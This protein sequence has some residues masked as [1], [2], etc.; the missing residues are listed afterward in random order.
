MTT[1]II[2]F[3]PVDNT[4]LT[5]KTDRVILYEKFA[6]QSN[7]PAH[8]FDM[9]ME[10]TELNDDI[11]INSNIPSVI[12]KNVLKFC[13]PIIKDIPDIIIKAK[14]VDI[15]NK[16]NKTKPVDLT[17]HQDYY[18]ISLQ[19]ESPI[20][21][22]IENDKYN[23]LNHI[24]IPKH[25]TFNI[26]GLLIPPYFAQLI[27]TSD[28]NYFNGVH[29]NELLMTGSYGLNDFQSN[30]FTQI[31]FDGLRINNILNGND[32]IY[33]SS[34]S[35]SIYKIGIIT[36]YIEHII[37]QYNTSMNML[38]RYI[39][40]YPYVDYI[41]KISD[42]FNI[43]NYT[44]KTFNNKYKPTDID[45]KL[46]SILQTAVG[47][48]KYQTDFIFN[49]NNVFNEYQK[50]TLLGINNSSSKRI[51]QDLNTKNK[52]TEIMME[53][54]KMKFKRLLEY[55]K[56]RAIS[57]RKFNIEQLSNLSEA[58]NKILIIEY[59]KNEKKKVDYAEYNDVFKLVESLN[60]FVILGNVKPIQN[61]MNEL[62]K[63]IT[64]P[65]DLNH[66]SKDMAMI[67]NSK[68]ISIVCPHLIYKAQFIIKHNDN[69]H[70]QNSKDHVENIIKIR[71]NIINKYALPIVDSGYFC[72]I[73]GELL[74]E[75][76]EE[77]I[78]KYISGKSTMSNMDMDPYMSVIW[79]EV[80]HIL[81]TYVKFKNTV[82]Y[83]ILV[84]SITSVLRPEM[85]M[86]LVNLSKV[87]INSSDNIKDIMDIYITCYTM[88]LVVNMILK[89]YGQISLV[90]QYTGGSS[91]KSKHS[92]LI[93]YK[94]KT[95]SKFIEKN[96]VS[97]IPIQRNQDGYEADIDRSYDNTQ[98]IIGGDDKTDQT[99]ITDLL[100]N[101][102]LLIL[103]IKNVNINKL[104]NMS[105]DSIKPILLKAYKWVT[106]LKTDKLN[107][108]IVDRGGGQIDIYND[109]ICNYIKYVLKM[110]NM[111]Q[112]SQKSINNKLDLK[113]I[114]GRTM[115]EIV[116][117][118]KKDKSIYETAN[119]G[120]QWVDTDI[121]KYK[122]NSYICM[123]EY[124]KNKLYLRDRFDNNSEFG[125]HM[126]K[127][128]Y[129]KTIEELIHI[130]YKIN[131]L[132]PFNAI[133]MTIIN[134]MNDFDPDKFRIDKLYDN[135]GKKHKFDIYIYQKSNNRGVLSG[136]KK[137][138]T[139]SDIIKWM[140]D[141][142]TKKI[143][144][145]K[146]WFIIDEKC[147]ICGDLLSQTKNISVDKEI[148]K[149][150]N[151]VNFYEYYNNK[152][153]KFDIHNYDNVVNSSNKRNTINEKQ[154][155][156]CNLTK[157][158]IDN[159]DISYYDKYKSL[160]EKSQIELHRLHQV[161]VKVLSQKVIITQKQNKYPKWVISTTNIADIS[162]KFGIKYNVWIN[163]GLSI[164]KDYTMIENEKINPS[165]NILES[166]S[167][168]R[169]IQ[170]YN[171][172]LNVIFLINLIKNYTIVSYIP[173]ELK[174]I[175]AKNK[176]EDLNRKITINSTDILD[177]YDYYKNNMLPIYNSNY[178]LHS[179]SFIILDFYDKLKKLNVTGYK[180]LT[181]YI[182]NSILTTERLISEP[183]IVMFKKTFSNIN[184]N[185]INDIN[186]SNDDSESDDKDNGAVSSENE[187]TLF[188]L[189]DSDENDFNVGDLDIEI[190]E[191]DGIS[192]PTDF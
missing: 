128:K 125:I 190:D 145:F 160:Y 58:Q 104:N 107:S 69:K 135:K 192:I 112:S 75:S 64:I 18:N 162:K 134:S 105:V 165:T 28:L 17:L 178:L 48:S 70:K 53:Y 123:L 54:H 63:I 154:C 102:L 183:N 77:E 88:A 13:I 186:I 26:I 41:K 113:N 33:F 143:S 109:N 177:K 189:N 170:L 61:I 74:A 8:H 157:N 175:L 23:N 5:N 130:D 96:H 108:D 56:K 87:K 31:K 169:N 141:K 90:K 191:E 89:N 133:P 122:Y 12:I 15:F 35:D 126:N 27:K 24:I 138:Y 93:K 59:T 50:I 136:P 152:C 166:D 7:L 144:E 142:D 111:Y 43:F 65:K 9:F 179:I 68:K 174:S 4:T 120:H 155:I 167:I 52:H 78:A 55:T 81:T 184:D 131:T 39:H 73:C 124:I 147:S 148:S 187:K 45:I 6:K 140:A 168:L 129:L 101:A 150:D 60:R 97:A 76:D 21:C 84:N 117:D 1:Q 82:N 182:I 100:N 40:D 94:R 20:N 161:D 137:E 80:V 159:L 66:T 92:R 62:S 32:I 57:I 106:S 95:K 11:R 127:Y 156:K 25:I 164:N 163:L 146:Y 2:V 83:K 153:P 79:K 180:D 3:K 176:I 67:E 99:R 30:D 103:R 19:Y 118:F 172:L 38:C 47:S 34:D 158:K 116:D 85:G 173:Y 115:P 86:I 36:V 44:K 91:K 42:S 132:M 46:S 185:E 110:N 37:K 10:M 72:K 49:I 181:L 98:L 22:I 51:I 121:G 119:E 114:L 71:E 14:H 139:K 171:Y 151:I 149:Y 16:N 29:P 188:E